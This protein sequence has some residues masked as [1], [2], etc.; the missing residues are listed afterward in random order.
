ML[1]FDMKMNPHKKWCIATVSVTALCLIAV[2]GLTMLIDPFFHYHKPLAGLSYSFGN[3]NYV[4]S[5]IVRHFEYDTL[6]TGTSMVQNFRSSLFQEVLGDNAVKVPFA[7]G[8]TKNLSALLEIALK[9][10]PEIRKVYLGLDLN[11]LDDEDPGLP[12][13]PFPAYL[14]DENPF[15]DA[16]YLLNKD[17]LILNVG[18]FILK[19]VAGLPSATFDEYSASPDDL[20]CGR[21]AVLQYFDPA[22]HD[23]INSIPRNELIISYNEHL[24]NFVPLIMA[25]PQVEFV[26]F[27]PP[28]S[29]LYWYEIDIENILAALSFTIEALIPYDNVCL[30]FPIN[31]PDI[32]TNL[33]NYHD[34]GHYTA[35]ISDYLVY[36][37]KD[38]THLLTLENYQEE[39]NKLTEMVNNFDYDLLINGN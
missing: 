25:Y 37:F 30:F 34:D 35:A 22:K 8:K 23:R 14:Y 17:V 9:A 1:G 2:A 28:Y 11:M 18:P 3:Q 21:D 31:N 26:I 36:C 6:I 20:D 5:G 13:E 4:N 38:G 33:D 10:N 16:A 12:R 15:N 29:I 19:T 27:I 24:H 7:G 39:L 32:V